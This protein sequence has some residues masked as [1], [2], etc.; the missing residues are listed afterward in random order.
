MIA[1]LIDEA[2][3]RGMAYIEV[4]VEEQRR[5]NEWVS[6]ALVGTV[7]EAGGCRSWYRI[8]GTGKIVSRFPGGL[9]R[10][11]EMMAATHAEE[12]RFDPAQ[13]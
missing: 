5:Y 2:A 4:S 7:W 8:D 12:L 9:T 10:F 6:A 1:R 3:I 13:V 11:E